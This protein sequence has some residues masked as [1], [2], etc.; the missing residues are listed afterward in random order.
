M[1]ISSIG[2]ALMTTLVLGLSGG[3]SVRADDGAGRSSHGDRPAH[4]MVTPG[5]LK[6]ID[7]PPSLPP[8]ARMAAI[9]G[10]PS[11]PGAF[12]MRVQLPANYRIPAHW[13]PADEHVTVLSGTFHMGLGDRLDTAR[14]KALPVGGFAVMPAKSN[15]FAWTTEPTVIQLHGIGPWQ[16]NY[17]NSADDPR[18]TKAGATRP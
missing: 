7:G 13:H 11:K 4:V 1:K 3:Y 5:D 10:D 2:A 6:W 17:L 8:G 14:G 9:E 16:I 15:H 12:T 18:N